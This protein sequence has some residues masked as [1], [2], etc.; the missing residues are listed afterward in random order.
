M[1]GMEPRWYYDSLRYSEGPGGCLGD[2]PTGIVSQVAADMAK[3][4]DLTNRVIG[5]DFAED[6]FEYG[7]HTCCPVPHDDNIDKMT[8]IY[9]NEV[10][11][12][13]D[14]DFVVSR[15]YGAHGFDPD[16]KVHKHYDKSIGLTHYWQYKVEPEEKKA[17]SE[18]QL[19][20]IGHP[21]P[22]FKMTVTLDPF[23]PQTARYEK[24]WTVC[25]PKF[26][27]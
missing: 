12:S 8:H 17:T 23:K 13:N 10:T 19:D 5:G 24:E 1:A 11:Y 14:P 15:L 16:R 20:V 4:N 27:E 6:R 7:G 9:D 3:L 25:G 2:K 21:D 26:D 22:P 18:T